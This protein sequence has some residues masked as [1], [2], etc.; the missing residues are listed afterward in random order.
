ME[1]VK[2]SIIK[3]WADLPWSLFD[4]SIADD[5]TLFGTQAI[6]ASGQ[7]QALLE[8]RTLTLEKVKACLQRMSPQVLEDILE[9]NTLMNSEVHMF[10][11]IV[12]Y[13]VNSIASGPFAIQ[14]LLQQ[15]EM[16]TAKDYIQTHERALLLT[17]LFDKIHCLKVIFSSGKD[18]SIGL[19]AKEEIDGTANA[20]T[21]EQEEGVQAVT[22]PSAKKKRQAA[23]KS[24]TVAKARRG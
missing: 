19:T 11:R 17:S 15:P 4:K 18:G 22:T 6:S 9:A 7:I 23:H 14:S 13:I 2:E 12:D 16:A 21:Q 3:A 8:E 10:S 5:A 1:S 20:C 24:N